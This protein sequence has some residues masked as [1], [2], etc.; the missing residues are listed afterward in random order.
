M[1]DK[2]LIKIE[3]EF[4]DILNIDELK[5]LL[6]K[7]W[8]KK[9]LEKFDVEK[10]AVWRYNAPFYMKYN[11]DLK[12]TEYVVTNINITRSYK[13][14]QFSCNYCFIYSTIQNGVLHPE[15]ICIDGTYKSADGEFRKNF[16]PYKQFMGVYHENVELLEPMENYV[17]KLLESG[18]IIKT[19]TRFPQSTKFKTKKGGGPYSGKLDYVKK[20]RKETKQYVND[21]VDKNRLPII[22]YTMLFLLECHRHDK[23]LNSTHMTP[24][25]DLIVCNPTDLKFYRSLDIDIR[26]KYLPV[27]MDIVRMNIG[28]NSITLGQ[29]IIPIRTKE[30]EHLEDVRYPIWKE[31]YINKIAQDLVFNCILFGIPYYAGYFLINGNDKDMYDNKTNQDKIDHSEV[32]KNMVLQ[33]QAARQYAFVNDNINSSDLQ[34][35]YK[36]SELDDE[37]KIPINYAERNLIMSNYAVCAISEIAGRTF[38]DIPILL[39]NDRYAESLGPIFKDSNC[40]ARYMFEYMYNIY[41][42]NK[43]VGVIHGDL[44]ANNITMYSRWF[45]PRDEMIKIIFKVT[46]TCYM[47]DHYGKHSCIIDFSR[48]LLDRRALKNLQIN[49]SIYSDADIEDIIQK[50][51]KAI[52]QK[53]ENGLPEFYKENAG[54]L[55]DALERAPDAFFKLFTAYDVF[56]VSYAIKMTI[57]KIMENVV[58]IEKVIDSKMMD[59]TAFPLLDKLRYEAQEILTVRMEKLFADLNDDHVKD[60][61]IPGIL[62]VVFKRFQMDVCE[63]PFGASGKSNIAF[64]DYFNAD[65]K[66]T[67]FLKDEKTYPDF[68]KIG[69][70]NKDIPHMGMIKKY[71]DYQE[72]KKLEKPR[73]KLLQIVDDYIEENK[74]DMEEIHNLMKYKIGED[75]NKHFETTTTFSL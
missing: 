30:M 70:Y 69:S 66:M 6:K 60:Y 7:D 55:T 72:Y 31:L 47:F 42:L 32:A 52:L 26:E 20:T 24:G 75:G 73:A 44:H 21:W 45:Y 1:S 28:K 41:C 33:L 62:D 39:L 14:M 49:E 15:Y 51:N 29:K 18:C 56:H 50:Q 65:K 22:T 57:K 27:Y 58:G 46:D 10:S 37:I 13:T 63:S 16:T 4:T 61:P 38:G 64:S 36:F 71:K 3:K 35:T 40:F 53:Y 2:V 19:T 48:S 74:P 43:H 59:S 12:Y 8:H 17:I 9:L 34:H 5:K 11:L 68:M 67:M 25:Y 54:K 23:N